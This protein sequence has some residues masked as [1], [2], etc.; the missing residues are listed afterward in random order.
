MGN[1]LRGWDGYLNTAPVGSF[2]SNRFGL[3][4][5]GGNADEWCADWWSDTKKETRVVRGADW[6]S[7]DRKWLLAATRGGFPPDNRI[8]MIGFRCVLAPSTP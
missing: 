3:Y 5:L 6:T 4:D 8:G 7:N 1:I 2:A